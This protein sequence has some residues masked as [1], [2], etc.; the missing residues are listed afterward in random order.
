MQFSQL[1]FLLLEHHGRESFL[2]SIKKWWSVEWHYCSS[3]LSTVSLLPSISILPTTYLL[4]KTIACAIIYQKSSISVQSFFSPKYLR[5]LVEVAMFSSLLFFWGLK[6]VHL[7]I[8]Y[9]SVRNMLVLFPRIKN[10]CTR[11]FCFKEVMESYRHK[12]LF[13]SNP[14][15]R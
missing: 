10:L 15:Y 3:R 1:I 2:D 13:H 5:L 4:Y 6:K 14:R 7:S 12:T 8:L 11:Y 9:I